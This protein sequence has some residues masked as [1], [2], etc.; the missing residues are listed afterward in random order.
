MLIREFDEHKD[1][2]ALRACVIEL[3]DFER[4]LDPRRPSGVDIVDAYIPKLLERCKKCQ[5]KILVAEDTPDVAS[6]IAELPVTEA[7]E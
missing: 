6:D 4:S 3:Q 7:D 5:G 2:N 1:L